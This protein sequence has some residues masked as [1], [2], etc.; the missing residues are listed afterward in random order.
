MR[1]FRLKIEKGWMMWCLMALLCVALPLSAAQKEPRMTRVYMFGF[2]ASLTDSTAY[3]TD[4]QAIDSAWIDPTHK[5]LIDRALYSLQL[6][7]HVETEE[8]HKNTVCTVFFNT[9]PRKVQRKWAKVRKRHEKDPA[10]KYQIL[11]QD[12][13]KFKA[14][15]YR[16]VIIGEPAV[17][18]DSTRTTPPAKPG[19]VPP[20]GKNPK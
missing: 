16:P 3:Q 19:P 10:L 11:P 12:R 18:A 4:I 8:H 17:V 2:A 20:D 7:Y 9:N 6:Q 5:F 13:F 14:E 1:M 15:E